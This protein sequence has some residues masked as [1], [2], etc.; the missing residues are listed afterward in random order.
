MWTIETIE[1]CLFRVKFCKRKWTKTKHPK[2]PW[3]M[4][5]FFHDCIFVIYFPLLYL[6]NIQRGCKAYKLWQQEFYPK[7]GW[8]MKVIQCVSWFQLLYIILPKFIVSF[9]LHLYTLSF[10]SGPQ[11]V[12]CLACWQSRLR[13]CEPLCSQKLLLVRGDSCRSAVCTTLVQ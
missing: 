9:K 13:L 5:Y 11:A 6:K 3:S 4:N 7:L 12:A 8:E 10:S 1:S 2:S